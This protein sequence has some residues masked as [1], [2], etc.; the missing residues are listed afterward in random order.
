M[1]K[2]PKPHTSW[3]KKNVYFDMEHMRVVG[4]AVK[5]VVCAECLG[6][7]AIPWCDN[8]RPDEYDECPECEGKGEW[9]EPEF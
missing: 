5:K 3:E 4:R 2:K 7:G 1:V 9:F 8:P 6:A